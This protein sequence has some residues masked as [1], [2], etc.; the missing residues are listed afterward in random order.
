MSGPRDK[1]DAARYR[2]PDVDDEEIAA[3]P[4][5]RGRNAEWHAER[6]AIRGQDYVAADIIYRACVA[7][8]AGGADSGF[9]LSVLDEFAYAYNARLLDGEKLRLDRAQFNFVG[10]TLIRFMRAEWIAKRE[11]D[12]ARDAHARASTTRRIIGT[13][14]SPATSNPLVVRTPKPGA[15]AR[16][17]AL[18]GG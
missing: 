1:Y 17:G 14:K 3:A 4:A 12:R 10:R 8:G 15:L 6:F 18:Y 5:P 9:A 7:Y 2:E 16:R 11:A 13:T